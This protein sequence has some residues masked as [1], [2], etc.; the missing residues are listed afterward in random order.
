MGNNSQNNTHKNYEWAS[1]ISV[2]CYVAMALAVVT[3]LQDFRLEK[4][5]LIANNNLYY[6]EQKSKT[7]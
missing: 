7:N 3:F 1:A 6:N 2:S 4:K 5:F